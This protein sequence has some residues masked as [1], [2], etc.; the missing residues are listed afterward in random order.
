MQKEAA[1]GVTLTRPGRNDVHSSHERCE[2]G[3]RDWALRLVS[4]LGTNSSFAVRVAVQESLGLLSP[5]ILF[6]IRRLR[7]RCHP[8]W[9]MVWIGQCEHLLTERF[10]RFF[11]VAFSQHCL[12]PCWFLNSAVTPAHTTR[13]NASTAF[14]IVE[15]PEVRMVIPRHRT[16]SMLLVI[17]KMRQT[18]V[19]ATKCIVKME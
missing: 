2:H 1:C 11:L 7:T 3:H 12:V 13:K 18:R 19:H 16:P 15:L 6:G 14:L 10:V 8:D 9:T 5:F 17:G 4:I